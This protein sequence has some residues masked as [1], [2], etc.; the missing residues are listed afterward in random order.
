[1][2]QLLAGLALFFGMHSMSIAALPRRDKF[3]AKSQIG[4]KLAYGHCC[5]I[6]MA[7]DA[8]KRNRKLKYGWLSFVGDMNLALGNCPASPAA[9][10]YAQ[11]RLEAAPTLLLA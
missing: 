7:W 1:M 8:M 9:D 10:S 5:P 2:L 3:P 6:K 11:S 4:W